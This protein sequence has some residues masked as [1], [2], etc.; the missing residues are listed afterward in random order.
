MDYVGG[1][2]D[3]CDADLVAIGFVRV[4]RDEWESST[5]QRVRW[6]GSPEKLKGIEGEG[7]TF[8]LRLGCDA[9]LRREAVVRRFRLCTMPEYV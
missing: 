2:L 3:K 8:V 7:R 1:E 5:G 6:V 9:D 4:R